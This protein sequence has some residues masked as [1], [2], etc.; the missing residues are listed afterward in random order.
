MSHDQVPT[1]TDRFSAHCDP[2]DRK[3]VRPLPDHATEGVD[4][5]WVRCNECEQIYPAT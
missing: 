2:C 3:V 1:Y 4:S 5:I